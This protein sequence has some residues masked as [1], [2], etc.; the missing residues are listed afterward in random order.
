L[1]EGGSW[2]EAL[3]STVSH[4]TTSPTAEA[5]VYATVLITGVSPNGLG[6][7][8]ALALAT[9]NPALLILASRTKAKLHAV[10][11]E[12]RA[13]SPDVNLKEIIVDLSS[14]NS[15]R[16]A[17]EEIAGTVSKNGTIDVLFNN[18]G[19]NISEHRFTEKG[20]EMQFATNHLGPFLLTNLLLPVILRGG[21]AKRIVNTSSEA[22]RISPVRFSDINQEPG[23]VI[24]QEDMPRR[25]LPKGMLRG[26]G[27]YEPAVA[28][29]Q[30]KTANVLFAI[31]L[32]ERLA[33]KRLK[34]LAVMPGG[35]FDDS[36]KLRILKGIRAF[37][38]ANVLI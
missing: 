22:H 10:A 1:G 19:I 31:G 13:S 35:E 32:N 2:T 38:K 15:V 12:I 16:G 33:R 18:A 28:Y 26:K 21:D 17:A 37:T 20:V 23:K 4:T 27:G 25:G 7:A 8:L 9:Q 11:T 29:G 14:L 5:D 36:P 24:E 6:E 3:L 30:S 34:C